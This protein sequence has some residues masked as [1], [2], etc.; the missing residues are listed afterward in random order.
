MEN[1]YFH[2]CLNRIA[3]NLKSLIFRVHYHDNILHLADKL[4]FLNYGNGNGNGYGN[5]IH[6]PFPE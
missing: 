1:L 5:D 3:L 6:N 4:T 2:M